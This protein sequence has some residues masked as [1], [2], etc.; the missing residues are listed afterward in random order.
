MVNLV[1]LPDGRKYMVDVGFGS[2]GPT[3]PL[4][5]VNSLDT[6][7]TIPGIGPQ[8]L[9]LIYSNIAPNTDPHQRLWI[10]QRRQTPDD[11]WSAAY[12]FVELEFLP[13]DYSIMNFWTSQSKSVFFTHTIVSVKMI[14]EGEAVIGQYIMFGAE[15]KRKIKGESETLVSCKNE[16]ERVNALEKWF[17]L[18]LTEDERRGIK[19]LVTELKG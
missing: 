1:T 18:I 17:G 8:Q 3:R 6:G 14:M 2:D 4:P 7:D 12:C 9:R 15:V 5:L 19:G 10:S 11:E 13:Q 16:G